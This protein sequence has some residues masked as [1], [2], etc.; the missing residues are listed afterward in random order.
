MRYLA[1]IIL[2]LYG[3]L[4]GMSAQD[5]NQFTF[6][7]P[8]GKSAAVCLT[9]DDGLDCHLDI[10]APALESFGFKGTFYCT[11]FSSSLSKRMEDWRSMAQR[12]HELGNHTLFHPCHGDKFEWIKPEYDLNHYTFDQLKNEL[13]TANVL[14]KAVDGLQE[15]TF[16]YTCANYTIDGISFADSI[17]GLFPAARG[18]DRWL[19]L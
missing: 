14:L 7:W 15:R 6:S 11:G 17:Q 18:E 10:A 4:S 13:R 8:D 19:N 2:F 16:A 1:L 12:G 9:Y 5:N 3:S